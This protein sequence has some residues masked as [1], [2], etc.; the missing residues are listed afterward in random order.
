MNSEK[1]ENRWNFSEINANFSIEILSQPLV[2]PEIRDYSLVGTS[3][4]L[5]CKR[6]FL[7]CTAFHNIESRSHLHTN[8][9]GTFRIPKN[10]YRW[11]DVCAFSIP[12]TDTFAIQA[13]NMA[14]KIPVSGENVIFCGYPENE[15]TESYV[16]RT[17]IIRHY[18]ETKKCFF[19][20]G[21]CDQGMSGGPV[22]LKDSDGKWKA[23]AV[24]AA[25]LNKAENIRPGDR[26][27]DSELKDITGRIWDKF[28]NP[29]NCFIAYS[30][31]AL[32]VFNDHR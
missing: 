18:D 6:E 5:N 15:N 12:F 24:I 13:I 27:E 16:C 19:I 22:L 29:E 10:I 8:Q 32:E 25:R 26:V 23:F 30:L 2:L 31:S 14:T 3:F 21:E 7:F 4:L 17:G 11:K 9:M 28:K 20:E 1:T